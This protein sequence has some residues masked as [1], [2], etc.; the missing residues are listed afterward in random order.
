[1]LNNQWFV[2]VLTSIVAAVILSLF[3]SIFSR[4]VRTVFLR[5]LLRLAGAGLCEYFSSQKA[6]TGAIRVAFKQAKEMRILAVRAWSI[7][8]VVTE[9]SQ[10]GDMVREKGDV[11][12]ARI[13]LLSPFVN[14]SGGEIDFMQ[15]RE[16][17]LN[18]IHPRDAAGLALRR[19]VSM[20]LDVLR[21][22]KQEGFNCTV[23][24]YNELP[25]FKILI[26]DDHAFVGGFNSANVGRN[27]P[28]YHV[29]RNEG[30]LFDL[31]HRY[32]EYIWE[33]QSSEYDLD[34]KV[35]SKVPEE[36]KE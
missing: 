35:V 28:V 22:L 12:A 3:L 27:N 36:G 32:F 10:V 23:R 18:H 2:G 6:A 9:L 34:L 29:R 15:R 24:L 31:A 17:E 25:V 26:F 20:T 4:R 7:F 33:H 14:E 11:R 16:A 5:G 30:L 19:Q 13:L 21:G 1:M 8:P